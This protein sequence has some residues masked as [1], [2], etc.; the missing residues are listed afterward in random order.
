MRSVYPGRQEA[1]HLVSQTLYP[2]SCTNRNDLIE[3]LN[4]T[5]TTLTPKQRDKSRK[6]RKWLKYVHSICDFLQ[7]HSRLPGRDAWVQIIA[8]L[9][10]PWMK[11]NSV[12]V[13]TIYGFDLCVSRQTGY[14]Y[15][16]YGYYEPGTMYVIQ[17]SL[18]QGD[19]FVDVGASVG[20]MTFLASDLVGDG[21][22]VLS[23]EPHNFRYAQ[24][25]DGI[26]I[27]NRS[28]I[29]TFNIGLGREK[30]MVRLYT[31]VYSPTMLPEK[32]GPNFQN[33]QV[34]TLD[35]ILGQ[36]QINDVRMVKIDVEGYECA[37]VQGAQKLLSSKNAPILSVEHG[38]YDSD[39][40]VISCIQKY[41]AYQTFQLQGTMRRVSKLRHIEN[42]QDLRPHDNVFCFLPHH[43]KELPEEMFV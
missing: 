40:D 18:R 36:W 29:R 39:S 5:E 4:V 17:K 13:P 20:Q 41:N 38:I 26:T 30:A 1:F 15:Y 37:V 21:G 6:L 34:D 11:K 9:L 42:P 43:L 32:K 14:Q 27:N 33:V 12:I 22:L 25:V 8:H 3:T 19:V 24:L 7:N 35:A 10:L 2:A 31:D 23:F 16:Y 28:N